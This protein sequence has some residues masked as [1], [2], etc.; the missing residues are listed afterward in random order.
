MFTRI[1]CIRNDWRELKV[2]EDKKNTDVMPIDHPSS[3]DIPVNR[4][5]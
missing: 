4:D 5:V 1:L 2:D 3:N